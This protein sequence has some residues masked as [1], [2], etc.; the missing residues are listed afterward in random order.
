[1]LRRLALALSAAVLAL[2]PSAR[3][4]TFP[5]NECGTVVQAVTCVM[6]ASDSGGLYVFNPSGFQV[7]D[8]VNV[9]GTVDPGCFSFCQQGN[10][11][12]LAGATVTSCG[13]GTMY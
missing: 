13:P 3:A 11:C 2:A 9:S 5:I 10:G 4:Q 1:M 6:F 7:G 8:Y 12:V